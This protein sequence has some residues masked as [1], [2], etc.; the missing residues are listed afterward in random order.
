MPVQA[1]QWSE[2]LCC[3][4]CQNEFEVKKKLRKISNLE[5]TIDLDTFLRINTEIH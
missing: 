2:Y 1:P 5:A 4:V 3:P